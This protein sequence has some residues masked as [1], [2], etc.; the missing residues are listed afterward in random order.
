MSPD[1]TAQQ[2]SQIV[3]SIDPKSYDVQPCHP[4][5]HWPF[6]ANKRRIDGEYPAQKP[7]F[8]R[9]QRRSVSQHIARRFSIRLSP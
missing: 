8:Q 7:N 1:V 2:I 9:P 6:Q 4:R 5:Q 3:S